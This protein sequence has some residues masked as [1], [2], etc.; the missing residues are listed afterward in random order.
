MNYV[1]QNL[2]G[3]YKKTKMGLAVMI[4]TAIGT[5]VTYNSI[6]SNAC[7]EV[8][9]EQ[10][11]TEETTE[12]ELTAGISNALLDIF[13]EYD[14]SNG[15]SY[16]K[17]DIKFNDVGIVSQ[18]CVSNDKVM[19]NDGTEVEE[20]EE[21]EIEIEVIEE[22]IESTNKLYCMKETVD[23]YTY[24]S[25][26]AFEYQDYLWKMCEKY[27]ITDYYTLMLAQAYHESGYDENCISSTNDY[28]LFQINKCNHKWLSENIF[29]FET[30]HNFLD[31]YENIEA[32]CYFMGYFLHKYNDVH[33][34]LVC[35]NRGES[36]VKKGIY[37]TSYS[38][39][40]LKDMEFLVEVE[41]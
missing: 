20:I 11:S 23:G 18:D 9:T 25:T 8:D 37:S 35:Y 29:K 40:V 12:Y 32:A 1:S 19:E 5:M 27:E 33:K 16:N 22:V 38:T 34:A 21:T 13:N 41:K 24:T 7:Q 17:L 30:V 6:T 15:T 4:L 31:P 10:I 39:G 28:G 36:T 2:P 26:L 14:L 3:F